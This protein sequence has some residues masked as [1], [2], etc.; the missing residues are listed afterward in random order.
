MSQYQIIDYN[1]IDDLINFISLRNKISPHRLKEKLHIIYLEGYLKEIHVQSFI[2]EENYF[3]RDF[4]E[5]YSAY[6]VRSFNDYKR[7]CTRLHFFSCKIKDQ[8]FTDALL[9]K[10][11]ILQSNYLGFIVLKPLP[12]T[13][14]GR[15]C[16]KT[17]EVT[18]GRSFNFIRPYE[19][20][21][22]GISLTVDS[23]AYQE[24]DS[25]V[26][27]CASSAIWSAF[28]A[29]GLL[30][31]HSIPSPVEI[32][33]AAIKFFPYSNRHF[34]NKGLTP[35]QMAHAIRNVGLD[36][37]LISPTHH[38]VLKATV[39][40]YLK[41]KI[42]IV[43]GVHLIEEHPGIRKPIGY[44]AI[45]V[46]GYRLGSK[47][48]GFSGGQFFLKSSS[49]EKIYCHDD[50][51]GPFARMEFKGA[52]NSLTTS[53]TDSNKKIGN[54]F[55]TPQMAIIPLYHKIR[56]SVDII[57]KVIDRIDSFVKHIFKSV[58]LTTSLNLSEIE[59]DI[60][61]ST[62]NDFK[63]EI[64][65]DNELSDDTKKIILTRGF[66]KYLWRAIGQID[67][68]R[69][70]FTFD[71]TDIEQGDIFIM[72]IPY[73]KSLN[74]LMKIIANNIDIDKIE[75]IPAEKVFTGIKNS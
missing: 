51:V 8:N 46:T 26:A 74:D 57:L 64:R 27:A 3:D 28:Q 62:N 54:V 49:I 17:Y 12:Q 44:H 63:K 32:T 24:Q 18:G 73:S 55:A 20:N 50:Q 68:E 7:T 66:P 48:Q 41:A 6:Y 70:E 72:L 58:T 11:S 71:A 29:T 56:I 10:S 23:I 59:W 42:P 13:I 53:W 67:N 75:L 15:T 19:V 21:L 34:P 37:F 16:L 60:F 30:F 35:E 65:K 69:I 22:F 36:P 9:D 38:D 40:A 5:D 2:T 4:L 39:Y 31:Q 61:L 1:S 52:G 47:K 25:I 14:I 33:R 45:T 43:L